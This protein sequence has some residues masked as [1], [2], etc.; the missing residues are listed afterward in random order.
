M[1][2]RNFRTPEH[3]KNRRQGQFLLGAILLIVGGLSLLS[4]L[5]ILPNV[6]EVL[7]DGWPVILIVIG[8]ILGTRSRFHN[9]A[10]FILILVGVANLFRPFE[11]MNGVMSNQLA[12]PILLVFFGLFFI[13]RKKKHQHNF[14]NQEQIISADSS[15]DI[16][17]IFGGKTEFVTSKDF[18]GGSI[19]T[20]FSG[21]ELN[22][23]QA[24]F[25]KELP[26]VIHINAFASGLEL[27]VPPQWQV[28]NEI[29]TIMGSVEDK[30][31]FAP[32]ASEFLKKTEN[33]LVLRGS[34]TMSAIEIKGY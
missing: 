11:V 9:P 32:P 23:I 28:R 16:D 14:R 22:L 7:Q 25:K 27:I 33:L 17:M 1:R 34:C 8:L 30:R 12:W 10:S 5:R 3:Q 6:R 15:L 31:G 24:D 26:I 19:K 20:L 13:F 18:T 21:L 4:R 2:Q 29:K